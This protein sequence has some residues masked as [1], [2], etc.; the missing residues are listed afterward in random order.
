MGADGGQTWGPMLIVVGD[1]EH[2]AGNPAVV[3]DTVRNRIVMVYARH[4]PFC[5][6][7]C[8]IGNG[9]VFSSNDGLTWTTPLDLDQ[10][11][12][13]ARNSMPGPGV[14]AQLTTGPYAGRI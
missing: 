2:R 14:M 13:V 11:F 8:V 7:N 3:F 1:H 4:G 5:G 6:G 10:Q 9:V 12:G